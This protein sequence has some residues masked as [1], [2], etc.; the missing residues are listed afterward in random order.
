MQAKLLIAVHLDMLLLRCFLLRCLC[1][2]L[3]QILRCLR[4]AEGCRHSRRADVHL[5]REV[6]RH[7]SIHPRPQP[8]PTLLSDRADS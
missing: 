6:R 8:T 7:C 5:R 1:N 4:S 2:R 3:G